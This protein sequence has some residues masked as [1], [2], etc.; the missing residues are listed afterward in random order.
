MSLYKLFKQVIGRWS[1]AD[2]L[3]LFGIITLLP[4][5][6]QTGNSSLCVS[7]VFNADAMSP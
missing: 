3:S 1:E 5:V 4:M 6:S 2:G 7:M